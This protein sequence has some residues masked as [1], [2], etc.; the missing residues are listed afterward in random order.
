[1]GNKIV[2]RIPER[3]PLI[4]SEIFLYELKNGNLKAILEQKEVG[5]ESR[6]DIILIYTI[7]ISLL[8]VMFSLKLLEKLRS[9]I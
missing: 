6:E 9:E 4:K 5:R 8:D 1:M 7:G 3:N 2:S